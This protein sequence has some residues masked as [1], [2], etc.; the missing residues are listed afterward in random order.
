[1]KILLILLLSIFIAGCMMGPQA[2]FS[3]RFRDTNVF[4]SADKV[5]AAEK[6]CIMLT[7]PFTLV[8]GS[9]TY[10]LPAGRYIAKMKNKTGYFYYAPS[11]ITSPNWFL[12][13]PEQGIYLDN[14]LT[15]GNLF[16]ADSQGYAD[17][18]I[19]NAVLPEG[20]FPYISKCPEEG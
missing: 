18:P 17:R 2:S 12:S 5:S 10:S 1:M 11:K 20:I 8:S 15:K 6:K 16:G 19:R 3:E 7:Q 9:V 13:F 4:T 14:Q